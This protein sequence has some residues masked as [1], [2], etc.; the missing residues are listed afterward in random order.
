M[1]TIWPL[2]YRRR[3]RSGA[4][5]PSSRLPYQIA[6][7]MLTTKVSILKQK[8]TDRDGY[9]P[10]EAVSSRVKTHDSIWPRRSAFAARSSRTTS[11]R[12]SSMSPE[13]ASPVV[14]CRTPTGSPPGSASNRTSL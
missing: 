10:I 13:S 11:A 8:F 12:T 14:A 7:S 1:S 3:R 2:D 9:C 6:I 4:R 5:T